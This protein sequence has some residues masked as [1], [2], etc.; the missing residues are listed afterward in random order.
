[1]IT[2]TRLNV[3]SIESRIWPCIADGLEFH[4]EL[5]T[6]FWTSLNPHQSYEKWVLEN[7]TALKL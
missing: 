3:L 2:D 6:F 4:F 1:M 7:L 5:F